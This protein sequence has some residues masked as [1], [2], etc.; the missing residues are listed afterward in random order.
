M[1]I[2]DEMDKVI[3]DKTIKNDSTRNRNL[4]RPITSIHIVLVITNLPRKKSP[5]IDDITGEFYQMFIEELMSVLH[6]LFQ[7]EETG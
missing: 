2:Y 1:D 7:K 3:E 4:I 6:K 5:G